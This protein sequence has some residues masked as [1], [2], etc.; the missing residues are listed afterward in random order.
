MKPPGLRSPIRK[1]K[2]RRGPVTPRRDKQNAKVAN[3]GH[4]T[5]E[6]AASRRPREQVKR[7]YTLHEKQSALA[8]LLCPHPPNHK[9]EW[10][11][12]GAKPQERVR[13]VSALSHMQGMRQH[14][15]Q[16]GN[17]Q[18]STFYSVGNVMRSEECAHD[19]QVLGTAQ[20]SC[21]SAVRPSGPN[22]ARGGRFRARFPRISAPSALREHE[23]R[24]TRCVRHDTLREPAAQG[25]SPA[26]AKTRPARYNFLKKRFLHG[27]GA[28]IECEKCTRTIR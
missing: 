12:G 15:P 18:G 27:K 28:S 16:K 26:S 19:I 1:S 11:R 7:V 8:S 23:A 13:G 14:P 22:S 4:G 17:L 2:Q 6:P 9:R 3:P 10:C 21:E 20:Q 5:R 24:P 25:V